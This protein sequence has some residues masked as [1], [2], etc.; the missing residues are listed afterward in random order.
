MIQVWL[1][2]VVG[3]I[4]IVSAFVQYFTNTPWWFM[5]NV[6][7]IFHEAGHVFLMFFGQTLHMLGGSLFEIAIPLF[8]LLYFSYK[9]QYFS[10]GFGA[11]WVSTALLS[12]SIYVSDAQERILPLLGGGAVNHDWHTL[13]SQWGLLTYDDLFGYLFWLTGLCA[14]FLIGYFIYQDRDVKAQILKFIK[15][16]VDLVKD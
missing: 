12:V 9:K 14:V 7:L 10:A 8:V 15:K 5:Q 3:L 6:N 1:K 2:I 16:E 11:W 13:L 4:L